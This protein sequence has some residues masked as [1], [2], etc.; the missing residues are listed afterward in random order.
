MSLATEKCHAYVSCRTVRR[1]HARAEARIRPG[2]HEGDLRIARCGAELGRNHSD[3][4]E[5]RKLG[6]GWEALERGVG[7][8]A[9]AAYGRKDDQTH[10]NPPRT[11][12]FGARVMLCLLARQNTRENKA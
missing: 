9:G 4:R 2:H 6:D 8:Q 3:R 7:R 5:T 10:P 12:Q 11:W 1:T